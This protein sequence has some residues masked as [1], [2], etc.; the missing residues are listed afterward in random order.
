MLGKSGQGLLTC[1]QAVEGA[2]LFSQRESGSGGP[3]G[4]LG[5]PVW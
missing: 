1:P 5:V 4:G 3:G 2:G